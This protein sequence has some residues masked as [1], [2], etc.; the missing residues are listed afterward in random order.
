MTSDVFRLFRPARQLGSVIFASPHSGRDYPADFLAQSL[1]DGRMIR[2]S[3]DAFVD[4]L[5][6]DAPVFGAPLLAATMPRAYLD[7]NR[8]PDEL[9]PA[10]I[11]GIAR[12]AHNPRVSSGLGVIP[13]VVAGGRAIYR[14]KLPLAEAEARILRC[15][16]PYHRALRDLIETTHG[17]FGQAVLIDC[18]SMPHEAIEGH[19]RPGA[20]RPDV[21]LGDRFGAAAGREMVERVEAA[22]AAAGLRV[23]RNAPFAGAF[24]A[25]SYG[26]PSAG[27]HVIQVE[28]DRSLYMDEAR[29]EKRADFGAFREVIAGVVAEIVGADRVRMPVA[30]E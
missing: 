9:D 1:L 15:W 24:I 4:Q 13:R 11:E 5:F 19:G 10:V 3:E 7:L 30:A 16:H 17:A 18:H 12:G 6:A 27:R 22:F 26:R 21:V 2:S 14:G 25:Q 28:I 8:A 20:V 23:A 29:V